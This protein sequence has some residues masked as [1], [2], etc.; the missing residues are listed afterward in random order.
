[1]LLGFGAFAELPFSYSGTEGNVTIVATKNQLTL[2]IGP[3]GQ[4]VTSVIEQAGPDALVLGTGEVTISANVNIDSGLKNPLILATGDVTVSGN[5]VVDSGLKNELI[6]SSG[7]VTITGNANVSIDGVPLILDSK[8]SG[9]ITWNEI[10]PG[11]TM[12]WTPI[13]PY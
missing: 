9:V 13:E 6:I 5:A 4:E 1:M 11:A 2:T 3:V 12:V 8:E 10:I 7:T